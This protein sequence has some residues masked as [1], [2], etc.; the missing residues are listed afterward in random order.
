MSSRSGKAPPAPASLVAAAIGDFDGDG[1]LE[2]AAGMTYH[3]AATGVLVRLYRFARNQ[4]GS[5]VTPLQLQHV[6]D[7][8]FSPPKQPPTAASI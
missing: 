4:D 8:S 1:Y 5:L 7:V 6:S 3:T 2:V